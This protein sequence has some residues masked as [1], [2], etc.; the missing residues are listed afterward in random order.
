MNKETKTCQNCKNDF[1]I[2]SEDFAFYEKM[3][4]SAPRLCPECRFKRRAV[5]RNEFMLYNRTCDLCHSKIVSMY[6]PSAPYTVYCPDCWHSDQWDP[7]SYMRDYDPRRPFLEQLGG[8]IRAV[9][10][11]ALYRSDVHVSIN[12]PYENFAGGNKDCYLVANSGPNNENCA[13]ARGMIK[14]R[15]VFDGYYVDKSE[16]IYEGVGIHNSAGIAWGQNVF[17]SLDSSYCIDCTGLQNC[18]GCVNLRHKSYHFLNKPLSREEYCRRVAAIQGSHRANKEFREQFE[19]FS[20]TFPR[21]ASNNLKSVDVSGN[22]I[23]ESK[24]CRT[25]FEVSYAENLH[26]AFSVKLAKDAYDMIGHGRSAELLLETVAVGYGSRIIAGWWVENCQKVEYSLA[27]R[28]SEHCFGCDGI[29]NAKYAILNKQYPEEEYKR[30]RAQIVEELRHA[31]EYGLFFPQ[32]L[33]LFSYNE[34]IGQENFPMTKEETLAQ[35]F[36]WEDELQMT[37]SKETMKPEEIHDHIRDVQ[38]SITNEILACIVC[39]RNYRIIPSELAF[40]RTMIVPIPRKCFYCRH[41]NRIERRGPMKIYDRTCD[42]CKKPIKTSYAPD[43][44]EIVYC[45]QCYQSEVI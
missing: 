3:G 43:R 26:Y 2:E 9:P 42:N 7:F 27:T 6:N 29:K 41:R 10:K 4:V 23:F 38:D 30:I 34:T 12:S 21:R 40:Y 45:E 36:R 24:N 31:G 25:S 35:G 37:T 32:A 39:R 44:P 14:C 16:R 22:Y 20:L 15:D 13:Y 19:R 5:F 28:G 1:T 11:S 17:D 33:A 8:L 18:F